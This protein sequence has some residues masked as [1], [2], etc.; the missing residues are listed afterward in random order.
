MNFCFGKRKSE[1][2]EEEDQRTLKE[3]VTLFGLPRLPDT[4]NLP[5]PKITN[6]N[7]LSISSK[8]KFD[9]VGTGNYTFE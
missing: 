9:N 4:L 2:K 1:I 3:S 6:K 7:L 5:G 8:V